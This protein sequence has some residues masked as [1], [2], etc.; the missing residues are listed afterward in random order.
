VAFSLAPA[1]AELEF[2]GGLF[3][4]NWTISLQELAIAQSSGTSDPNRVRRE[5]PF[6][7][8]GAGPEQTTL[9]L[10]TLPRP[11][12]LPATGREKKRTKVRE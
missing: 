11:E 6:C 9:V 8:S 4:P 1:V 12:A 2:R 7:F 10:G 5:F 3:Q